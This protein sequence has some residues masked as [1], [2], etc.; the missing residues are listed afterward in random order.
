M[1]NFLKETRKAL[2]NR[3]VDII[4]FIGSSDGQ[5]E[6]TWEEFVELADFEYDD[7]Y[8][9]SEIPGDFIIVLE[10]GATLTRWEYDGSEGW[11]LRK[12]VVAVL[13][14]KKIVNLNPRSQLYGVTYA[15][16][17]AEFQEELDAESQGWKDQAIE[18]GYYGS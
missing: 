18:D 4:E 2:D 17:I 9:S 6:C 1:V 8:G 3:L 12:P 7:G 15:G 5:Y 11:E 16:S 13:N 10:D 14:P